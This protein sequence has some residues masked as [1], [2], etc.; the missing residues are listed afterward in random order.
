[1]TLVSVGKTLIPL[2]LRNV[3]MKT[4]SC[5]LSHLYEHHTSTPIFPPHNIESLIYF[6]G[7][8]TQSQVH[9]HFLHWNVDQADRSQV[10]QEAS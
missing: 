4:P 9:H 6:I 10:A 5:L 2:I 7:K 3:T 8:N 1:M